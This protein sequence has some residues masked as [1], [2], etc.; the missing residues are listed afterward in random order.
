MNFLTGRHIP[1]RTFL[2]T[3]GATVGLPFLDAMV[4]A[5]RLWAADEIDRTLLICIENSKRRGWCRP[6]GRH[7]ELLVPRHRRARFRPEP[8]RAEPPRAVPG[9]PDH[10]QWHR[11][12]A[13]GVVQPV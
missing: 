5:G 8:E 2:R 12:T 7:A 9:L 11:H 6:L 13:G 3:A 1:R 10:H 4:P